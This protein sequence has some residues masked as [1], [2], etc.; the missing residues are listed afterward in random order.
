MKKENI[1][2]LINDIKNDIRTGMEQHNIPGMSIALVS[3]EG[4]I[5]SEGFGFI[6]KR[7]TRKVNSDT[8]FRIGSLS[9]A[10]GEGLNP[11]DYHYQKLTEITV[12]GLRTDNEKAEY[13]LLL[14]DAFLLYASHL[15]FG[16]VNPETIDA[17]WHVARR[18]GNP[19][20][21]LQKALHCRSEM[22]GYMWMQGC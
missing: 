10:T 12:N 3:K 19:V 4:I 16:K 6:D 11:E 1:S 21:I 20:K 22:G 5:W 8:L 14:T 13:D 18:E 9:K 7:E 2:T 15:M 17:E